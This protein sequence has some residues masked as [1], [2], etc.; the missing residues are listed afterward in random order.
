MLVEYERGDEPALVA[1]REVARAVETRE[2]V[3]DVAAPVAAAETHTR[4]VRREIVVGARRGVQREA[5]AVEPEGLRRHA[6]A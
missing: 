5:G 1:Q 3:V 2:L 6:V 4:D